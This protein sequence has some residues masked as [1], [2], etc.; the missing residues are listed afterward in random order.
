MRVPGIELSSVILSQA[1][2]LKIKMGYNLLI[3]LSLFQL[4]KLTI[5]IYI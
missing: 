1:N 3:T 4:S 2:M 5:I